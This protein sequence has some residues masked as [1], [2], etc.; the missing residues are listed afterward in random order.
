MYVAS[1]YAEKLYLEPAE[2]TNSLKLKA[3]FL[4]MAKTMY[5]VCTYTLNMD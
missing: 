1:I 5:T 2:V 3:I 4:V